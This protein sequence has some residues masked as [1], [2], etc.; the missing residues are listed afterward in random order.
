MEIKLFNNKNNNNRVKGKNCNKRKDNDY[1]NFV[2]KV[3]LSDIIYLFIMNF[4][5]NILF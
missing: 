3:L 1:K 4:L 2:N 5:F